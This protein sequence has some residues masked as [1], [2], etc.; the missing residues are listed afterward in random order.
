MPDIAIADF[1]ARHFDPDGFN[2]QPWRDGRLSHEAFVRSV[3]EA[4]ERTGKW[5]T[6]GEYRM[7]GDINVAIEAVQ[8]GEKAVA[9]G[10]S[11]TPTTRAYRVTAECGIAVSADYLSLDAALGTL[12]VFVDFAWGLVSQSQAWRGLVFH[13]P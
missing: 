3:E 2:G 9:D 7:G 10:E 4:L 1:Y 8:V 5:S 13:H 6:M 12:R 11:V